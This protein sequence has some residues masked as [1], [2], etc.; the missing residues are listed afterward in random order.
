MSPAHCMGT[1]TQT[2]TL[3]RRPRRHLLLLAT[4]RSTRFLLVLLQTE[5]EGGL[6]SAAERGSCSIP[7]KTS[8]VP[9][10]LLLPRQPPGTKQLLPFLDSFP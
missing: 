6:C 3:L 8:N 2:H 1:P 7:P 5:G 10:L 4:L 9:T